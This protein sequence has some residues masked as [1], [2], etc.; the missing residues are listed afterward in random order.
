MSKYP[1]PLYWMNKQKNV[2]RWK[3]VCCSLNRIIMVNYVVIIRC[4]QL[5]YIKHDLKSTCKC[6][7]IFRIKSIGK[8]KRIV[9]TCYENKS[10]CGYCLFMLVILISHYLRFLVPHHQLYNWYIRKMA[11]GQYENPHN[12]LDE[13]RWIWGIQRR[14]LWWRPRKVI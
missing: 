8:I 12:A 13:S 11:F 1:Q 14:H 9:V 10:Y 4:F 3:N 7:E 6:P 2:K 5:Q